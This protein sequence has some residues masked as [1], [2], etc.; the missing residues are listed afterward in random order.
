MKRLLLIFMVMMLGAAGAVRA[1]DP[2]PD[3]EAR[4]QALLTAAKSGSGPVDWQALRFA[5]SDRPSFDEV[6]FSLQ[7]LRQAMMQARQAHDF[8]KMLAVARQ[9]IDK[10]YVDGLAHMMAMTAYAELKQ[11]ADSDRERAI[12]V[13]IFKSIETGDGL[14]AAAAFT[15]I[16]VG[17]EYE[18]MYALGRQVTQQSLVHQDGHSYDVLETVGPGG[19]KK[20]IYFQIDRVWARESK[21]FGGGQ[22]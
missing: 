2:A 9:I 8:A 18:L 14:S 20:T 16:S 6:D 13:G 12:S 5:F 3:P 11:Q 10:D 19:D 21:A 22:P 1:A 4:W 15:V 17:E 7:P